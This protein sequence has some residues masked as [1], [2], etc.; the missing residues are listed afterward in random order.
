MIWGYLDLVPW[1]VT[2][3]G[4]AFATVAAI[5][6]P[7]PKPFKTGCAALCGAVAVL[8]VGVI[9]G[10]DVQGVKIKQ[11]EHRVFQLTA[12]NEA[13]RAIQEKQIQDLTERNEA[14]RVLEN[15]IQSYEVELENGQATGC[16]ADP[17][18]NQRLQD[19]L[20]NLPTD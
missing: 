14:N 8:S 2:G 13:Y 7:L 19:I 15:V 4:A 17:V 20:G 12:Q 1:V 18:Y 16:V 11:L 10:K 5:A 6:S 3:G 9:I